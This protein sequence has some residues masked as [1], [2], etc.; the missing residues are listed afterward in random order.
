MYVKIKSW[1]F[2]ETKIEKIVLKQKK[3]IN[4]NKKVEIERLLNPK[5]F[6]NNDKLNCLVLV[7][8]SKNEL[9]RGTIIARPNIS[10]TDEIVI[11]PIKIIKSFF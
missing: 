4:I 3:I 11:K 5:K 1:C 2:H 8:I 10:N 9:I 6:E 7:S